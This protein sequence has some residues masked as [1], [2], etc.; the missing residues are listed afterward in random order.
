MIRLLGAM[1]GASKKAEPLTAWM[2][3]R[4]EE[5]RARRERLARRP[6]VFFE[7]WDDR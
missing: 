6:K 1:V 3:A 7:E 5:A 4:L 2:T